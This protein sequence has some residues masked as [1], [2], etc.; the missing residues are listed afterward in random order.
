MLK[1]YQS[2]LGHTWCGPSSCKAGTF[3]YS[4]H[5]EGKEA[6]TSWYHIDEETCAHLNE[7]IR[8]SV[9]KSDF[10]RSNGVE[11]YICMG[12]QGKLPITFQITIWKE[13]DT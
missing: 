5:I 13:D 3:H 8:A 12:T 4:W 2:T 10:R 9:R 1:D 7:K 11:L 6:L